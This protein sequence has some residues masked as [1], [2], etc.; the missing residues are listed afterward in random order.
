[1]TRSNLTPL[2]PLDEDLN[3]TLRHLDRERELAEARRGIKEEVIVE[4]GVDFEEERSE[5]EMAANRPSQGGAGTEEKPSTMLYYMALRSA[6]I[7]PT[8]RYPPEAANNFE[9]KSALVTMIQNN[10][11]FH[12]LSNESP[13]EHDQKFIKLRGG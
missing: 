1:M 10:A 13:R 2:A 7:Q 6:D 5:A 8:I 9:I 4:E 11:L 12:G 3:R